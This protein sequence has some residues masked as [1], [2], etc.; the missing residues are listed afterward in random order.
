MAPKGGGGKPGTSGANADKLKNVVVRGGGSAQ[1]RSGDVDMDH[2]T[3]NGR[4]A[5]VAMPTL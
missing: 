3:A 1:R 4:Q 5:P 2:A